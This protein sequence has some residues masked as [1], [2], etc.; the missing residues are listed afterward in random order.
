MVSMVVL[1][2]GVSQRVRASAKP[3]ERGSWANIVKSRQRVLWALMNNPAGKVLLLE[4]SRTARAAAEMVLRANIARR[5]QSAKWD[6]EESCVKMEA[7]QWE[8]FQIANASA[9]LDIRV[10]IVTLPPNVHVLPVDKRARM[11]V[12]SLAVCPIASVSA[13]LASRA[14][15]VKWQR[16][17]LLDLED[18]HVSMVAL[19]QEKSQI[20]SANAKDIGLALNAT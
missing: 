9:K 10:Q 6:P 1:P 7:C 15:F 11:E 3:G 2:S 13:H 20:A 8:I 5:L 4:L 19:H 18:L 14:S 12:L 16:H 17:V